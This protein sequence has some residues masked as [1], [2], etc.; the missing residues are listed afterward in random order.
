MK[1]GILTE[2]RL[3]TAAG[4]KLDKLID[5]WHRDVLVKNDQR[6]DIALG[7]RRECSSPIRGGIL[8]SA[9]IEMKDGNVKLMIWY[10]PLELFYEERIAEVGYS[11]KVIEEITAM[12]KDDRDPGMEYDP[13]SNPD[14]LD[15]GSIAGQIGRWL[16]KFRG[17]KKLKNENS[18]FFELE[19]FL[20][21]ECGIPALYSLFDEA[22]F[23]YFPIE[24][25]R[26][27]EVYEGLRTMDEPSKRLDRA[28]NAL[29]ISNIMEFSTASD[30]KT[31]LEEV[32]NARFPRIVEVKEDIDELKK[33]WDMTDAEGVNAFMRKFVLK[34]RLPGSWLSFDETTGVF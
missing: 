24:N 4:G 20:N 11:N 12:L 27:S 31:G 33:D 14:K 2:D 3:K 9:A 17:F 29:R 7:N 8:T 6:V 22:E 10:D 32:I 1:Y 30:I 28:L 21:L 26:L 34:Y 15:F 23:D 16:L 19:S 18:N 25:K 5:L 13:V